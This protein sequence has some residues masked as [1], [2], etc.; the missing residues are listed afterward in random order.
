MTITTTV[1]DGGVYDGVLPRAHLK[2]FASA[3]SYFPS[4]RT[5]IF[6]PLRRLFVLFLISSIA[7]CRRFFADFAR[8]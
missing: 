8:F 4:F 2:P 6:P 1:H 3:G 5:G 7:S